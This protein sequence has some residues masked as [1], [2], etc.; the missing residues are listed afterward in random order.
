MLAEWLCNPASRNLGLK[1][2]AFVRLR[3]E[4]TTSRR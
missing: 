1:E 2:L 3:V 4:M